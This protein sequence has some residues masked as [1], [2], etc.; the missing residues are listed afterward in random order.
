MNVPKVPVEIRGG[1]IRGAP[2]S[3]LW[4]RSL[5]DAMVACAC[6]GEAC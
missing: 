6:K 3:R 2:E 5:P 1:G 4:L